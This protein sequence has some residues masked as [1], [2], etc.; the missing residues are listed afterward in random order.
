[1]ANPNPS[2]GTRFGAP[3]GPDPVETGREGGLVKGPFYELRQ[4]HD[5]V[6]TEEREKW[7]ELGMRVANAEIREALGNLTPK[8]LKRLAEIV[9]HGEHRDAIRAIQVNLDRV[10]GKVGVSGR[11]EVDHNV[12]IMIDPGFA[13]LNERLNGPAKA[14]VELPAGDVTEEAG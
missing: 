11:S 4:R 12:T 3:D 2:P 10:A 9:E 13:A 8:S 5:R 7:I 1:M 14:D 6:L